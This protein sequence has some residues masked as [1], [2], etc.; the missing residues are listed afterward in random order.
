MDTPTIREAVALFDDPERLEQA[1]SDL[2]SHGFDHADL[3]LLA[4]EALGERPI[5]SARQLAQDPATPRTEPTTDTD[6]RQGRVLATGMAATVAGFAAAG[7]TVATGGVLAAV[8]AAGVLA[9]G[10]A[11]AAGTIVGRKI[12]RDAAISL[13]AQ[14]ARGGVLLWVHVPDAQRERIAIDLLRRYSTEVQ[15][16]EYPAD[17][18]LQGRPG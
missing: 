12:D 3:S 14:L 18:R 17:P 15:V 7:L 13:D 2:C 11:A 8:I 1:V 9:A 5:A 4:P 16:H 10:G 6:L